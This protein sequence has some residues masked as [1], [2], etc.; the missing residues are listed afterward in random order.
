MKH[1][2]RYTIRAFVGALVLLAAYATTTHA[3]TKANTNPPATNGQTNQP[4]LQASSTPVTGSGMAGRLSKWSGV[5]GVN[6]FTL[7][8]SGIFED[9]FFN[10]GIGTTTPTSKLTVAGM[11]ETTLGGLKF[12]D[13]TLQTTAANGLT[14]IFHNPTLTGNGTQGS[15]LGVAVPLGLFGPTAS[16]N[17]VLFVQNSGDGG[18]GV[19]AIGGP[20]S[21]N[22]AG[23][24]V[25]TRGG[26]SGSGIGGNGVTAIG[27]NSTSSIGGLGLFVTGGNSASGTGGAG[28]FATG[29]SGLLSNG[30]AGSFSGDVQIT[31]NLDITGSVSKGGGSFKI[32]HPLDPENRYLYHSF[33]ESP[34]MKNI[35]DGNAVTDENSEAII[36]LPDYFEALNKDFRYQ[37]TVIGQFAQA[38]V[39]EKI[40]GNRFKIR[41]SAPG[42]EVSWQVTGIRQDAWA[43][44]NRIPIE[45]E[46]PEPE[47][48][49]YLSPE[50]FNQPEERGVEWA[51]NPQ[52]MQQLKQQR[53]EAGQQLKQHKPVDR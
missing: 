46:K 12:P 15:P 51:R 27:G 48:G 25:F 50:S 52:R 22:V 34:D 16:G 1:R 32:D 9:K 6:T 28:L 14:S 7:G 41:T 35:Y 13:G 26:S 42:I 49:T 3:Q 24:G 38:I 53:M 2:W 36:T 33:V 17:S 5:S 20:S 47:R 44:K 10:I 40:K 23:D 43:N 45:E 21:A 39:A 19:T 8:D 11:I 29:G 18:S 30:L 31:G 37:L 4:A